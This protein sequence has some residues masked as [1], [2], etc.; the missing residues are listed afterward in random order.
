MTT[1]T[2]DRIGKAGESSSDEKQ[3]NSPTQLHLS[4]WI[5]FLGKDLMTGA[6]SQ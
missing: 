6:V 4:F 1:A 2:T 3:A 5:F